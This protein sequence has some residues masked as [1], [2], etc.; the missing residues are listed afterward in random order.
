MMLTAIPSR[1]AIEAE[2]QYRA[3]HKIEDLYPDAGPLRRELYV[4]HLE[5][6]RAGAA[7]AE[8]CFMAAN[9]VGKTEGVG[10]YEATAHLTGRYPAWWEGRRFNRPVSAW[11]AGKDGKTVRDILQR[12]LLGPAPQFGTGMIPADAIIG[13]TPKPGVPEAVESVYVKH[14]SGGRSELTFKSYE[15]GQESFYG[16][17]KDF[18]WL[19]EECELKIY[20]ECL[21]R[22]LAVV[23]GE[24]N[25]LMLLTYTPLWGMTDLA[26]EYLQAPEGSPKRLI[27]ATWDNAPHLS[28]ETRAELYKSIPPHEREARTEGRPMLGSGAI[29][30]IPE[31]DFVVDDF[32]VPD[33]FPRGYGMDVGWHKT[34]AIWGA[35]DRESDIAYLTSHH[36]RGQAEPIIHVEGIRARGDWIPGFID[37]AANGRSQIDGSQ[38]LQIYRRLGLNLQPA[39]NA[40]EAGIYEVWMRLSTGRLKVF[41][42]CMHWLDEF[43]I[44]ARDENGKIINEQ[45]F[46]LMA[47][48]R[49]LFM[50]G[51]IARW[52]VKPQPKP[53]DFGRHYAS[54]GGNPNAK[55]ME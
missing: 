4:K 48:T 46:H 15:A 40:R 19:D 26:K 32:E 5:F 9:R 13:T 42:S 33:H 29:Y 44:F 24:P 20:T 30:P 28:K 16:T 11:V 14:I 22:T 37:P 17:R 7:H 18:V 50:G 23:L 2:L 39:D 8:R 45:K 25:G 36:Y 10:A 38:L 51:M 35:W 43:R 41:R 52:I 12:A 21:L 53:P 47:A 27:T 55:W 34:A 54:Y 1:E 6:F 49:Y 3:Q 31:A